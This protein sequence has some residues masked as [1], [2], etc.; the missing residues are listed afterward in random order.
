M[1]KYDRTNYILRYWKEIEDGRAIVCEKIRKI[2]ERL[3]EDFRVKDGKYHFDIDRASRPIFF[4]ETFCRQSKGETGQPIKLQL[5]QKAAIQAIFGF[6]DDDGVRKHNE[7]LMILGRK[8]GKSVLLSALGLYMMIGDHEGGAEVDCVASK[9]DQAKIVFNESRNMVVQSP[10]LGRYIRKRKT[11]MY[12]DYNFGV[13]QPL[14]SDS[15]TLDGLNPSCGIIDELHSIKD[16]NI[17]D[18]VKQGMTARKQPILFIITTSGFNR[19]GIYDDMYSYA[20]RVLSGDIKDD[21]FLPIVYELD[22]S[23]EWNDPKMWIKANPGLGTIKSLDALKDNVAKAKADPKF[24]PTVLTKDFNI[25]NVT[26]ESWLTWEQLDNDATFTMDD[27]YNTYAIG[28]CDLSAVR[29]LTCA[30]LLIRKPDDE[31]IYVLQHYFLPAERVDYLETTS[32]K[33]AP[34]RIWAE[35]GLL[36]LCEGSMVNYSDVTEWYCKMRD[37]YK[38]SLWKL[39]YDRALAGYWAEQMSGEFGDS[40]MEKVAQGPFTWTAPMKELGA[41]LSDKK[42]NY[43]ANPMLKWCLSNT[44]VKATGSLDSIQPVKIQ[45][46]RRIDG[47]VSLL[48]AYV[49]YVKYRDDYLN[50]VGV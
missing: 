37:E 24:R 17:Y 21:H 7:V 22:K 11:D 38:I 33:E 9:K 28:G 35:R 39:G 25:K 6:V 19:E 13:F 12:C 8:N 23:T 18:V 41:M 5:F 32:S 2:Y 48:N 44:G 31:Q 45:A 20:E 40:V 4:V 15:N 43:N 36:T 30:T 16:R 1:I 26:S 47:M 29:D 42:I 10:Y 49:I 34:Y 14:S 27:I 50:T 3:A 46:N